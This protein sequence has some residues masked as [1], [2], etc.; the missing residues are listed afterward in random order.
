V[1]IGGGGGFYIIAIFVLVLSLFAQRRVQST[2]KKFSEV[3]NARGITGAQAAARILDSNG[4]S[5]VTVER[6]DGTLTDHYDP[7]SKTLR[8]SSGVYDAPSVAA[9]GIAAHEAGHALQDKSRYPALALR[10]AMVPTVQ[11]GSKLGPILF[12]IGV[13]IGLTPL[14]W[15]G[16]ILFAA[17]A[18]F[19]VVTLPVEFNASAR[20]KELLVADG[21]LAPQ[22][23]EGVNKVLNAAAWTYVVA[24]LSAVVWLLHYASILMGRRD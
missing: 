1:Y 10:S 22:E 24:A 20:A 8:L 12:I 23:M 16:L 15:L 2:F 4:L 13:L 5:N 21:I 14:A 18:L 3:R 6:V 7:R 17:V 11:F 19:S 9:V